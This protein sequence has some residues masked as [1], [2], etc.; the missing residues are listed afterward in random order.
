MTDSYRVINP[1]TLNPYVKVFCAF[2][3]QIKECGQIEVIR[4]EIF[5]DERGVNCHFASKKA[6]SAATS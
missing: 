1:H 3:Q 4:A 6:T 5:Q 2:C